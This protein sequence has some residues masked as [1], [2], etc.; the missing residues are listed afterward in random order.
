CIPPSPLLRGLLQFRSM[1]P[2]LAHPKHRLFSRRLLYSLLDRLS[3]GLLLVASRSIASPPC[4]VVTG[5]KVPLSLHGGLV[6][7][8]VPLLMFLRVARRHSFS[9]AQ[10]ASSLRDPNLLLSCPHA[11]CI[12]GDSPLRNC[13]CRVPSSMFAS[14]D[15]SLN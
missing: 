9:L 15:I 11:S 10:W 1:W 8:V 12:R 6:S 5:L 13:L 2:G 7:T 3:C 4:V 14:V